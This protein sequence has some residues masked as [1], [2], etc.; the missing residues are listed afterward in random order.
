MALLGLADPLPKHGKT[1]GYVRVPFS[2]ND[3][4]YGFIASPITVIANG[5]GPT[6]LLLAGTQG[7]EFEGQI[8]LSNLAREIEPDQIKG[9]IIIFPM[10]NTPA[11]QA[12]VR[13]SPIDGLNLNRIFPGDVR[14]RTTSMLASYIERALMPESDIVVDLHSGGNSL[15]YLSCASYVDHLNTDESFRRLALAA[16]FGAPTT[17]AMKAFEDRST[18]GAARRAGAVRVSAEIGG[19]GRV[20]KA[21]VDM[22]YNGIRNVLDWASILPFPDC[23][24]ADTNMM[25]V[26]AGRDYHYALHD[27]LFEPWVSLG[28]HV[29][30]GQIAGLIHDVATPGSAPQEVHF[31]AD[32]NVVCLRTMSMTKRGD[33][34]L[35]LAQL[36]SDNLLKNLEKAKAS[37]WL[38]D[39][40]EKN[41]RQRSRRPKASKGN[42]DAP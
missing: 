40:Y 37:T 39:S 29:K 10:A 17:L 26:E 34:V 35:H 20:S 36:P 30:E 23:Q 21:S 24:R 6:A 28:D 7:D 18:S 4:A 32:G 38:K 15:E 1:M 16:A 5:D 33:C 8:A 41:S 42:N 3:S 11:A 13:N 22:S 9:R 31:A 2:T 12:G 25:E 19:G 14:G 27:G